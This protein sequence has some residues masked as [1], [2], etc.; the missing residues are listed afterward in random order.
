M[1]EEKLTI[2]DLIKNNTLS[3][4]VAG[5]LWEAV[6]DE[7][8]FLTSAVY[9]N[10]GKST[11]SKAIL[12]LRKKDTPI[13]FV[14]ENISV[15]EK[16]LSMEKPGGYLV[17]SEFNPVQVPGYIWGEKTQQVFEIAKKGYSLQGCIHAESAEEAIVELTREN[18][19]TDEDAALVKLVLFIEMHG[20]T[21]ANAKRRLSQVYEVH[22][23]EN[24]EPKGH[25]LFEW[26]KESDS[27]IKT[28]EPHLFALNEE[29]ILKKSQILQNYVNMNKTTSEDLSNAISEFS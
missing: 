10:A 22:F 5:F 12:E 25:T 29:N 17:V 26:D 19:I 20:T 1:A 28:E 6:S 8:S 15:T 21:P 24:K 14:S 27:F 7:T 16:L 4:E 18:G 2:L 13:H 23:V 9:Q 11:L 3:S